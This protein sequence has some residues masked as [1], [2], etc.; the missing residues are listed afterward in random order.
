MATR[1]TRLIASLV[2]RV[3]AP[4][5]AMAGALDIINKAARRND[6]A[7]AAVQ[8]KLVSA[9][10]GAYVF[11]KSFASPI[12]AAMDFED[13]MA[14]VRKVVDF[15]T[16]AE[17]K[18][19][20][21]DV[22]EMSTR[23]P[24]AAKDLSAIVAA[25]GQS[26]FDKSVLLEFTELAA[27]VGVAFDISAGEAGTAL[28]K[29]S[30]GLGLTI[31]QVGALADSMNHLSNNSAASAKDVL[32]VVRRVGAMGKQFGFQA[33]Q[34]AG[35]A[36]AMVAAGAESEVAATSFRNMGLA[37]TKGGGATK[38]QRGAY[39]TLGLD[40]VKVAQ[41]MQKDAVGQTLDVLDR[42]NKLPKWQQAEV[43]NALFGSEARALGPLLTNLDMLRK[44]L[45]MV[46]KETKY[47][48][49]SQKEYEARAATFS[50]DLQLLRNR[51]NRVA[52]I[53]GTALIPAL[54]KGMDILEPVIDAFGRFADK[55][56]G[57]VRA[58]SLTAAALVS[59]R[60]AALAAQFAAL[61][62]KG[63]LLQ[64]AAIAL[65]S[66]L[67]C[68]KLVKAMLIAPVVGAV[69][70]AFRGLRA[71]VVGYAAA[72]AVAGHG[73]ALRMMLLGLLNPAKLA[74]GAIGLVTGALR[75]MKLALISTGIGAILVAI[76][77]AAVFIANNWRGMGQAAEAFGAAFQ[78]AVAPVE[79]LLRPVISAVSTVWGWFSKL[80]G[81][82]DA[83]GKKWEAW[84]TAAGEAV[85]A[86]VLA[87]TQFVQRAATWVSE[88]ASAISSSASQMY[89][90]G[91][92]MVQSLWDG[93]VAKFN[94]FIE[95]V[96][97]IPGRIRAAIG[98]I[99]L[100]N[101][102]K[103]PSFGSTPAA[104]APAGTRANG[105]PVSAG[106]PYLVGERGPELFVP[107][108]SGR[109][110]SSG[111]TR[112]L[113]AATVAGAVAGP[114]AAP[115]MAQ[116]ANVTITNHVTVTATTNTSAREIADQVTRELGNQMRRT[117][118]GTFADVI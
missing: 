94:A 76:G 96:K 34:V 21:A 33:P 73:A 24:M 112:A 102:I 79:P 23:I 87:M 95:W 41:R 11:A 32:D 26:G 66:A 63:A 2:D 29:L 36:A 52:V 114:M 99:D 43:S 30:T 42:I 90:A 37:L 3:T 20:Q 58:L 22:L 5:R 109:V 35:F 82:V 115:A 64:M 46:D 97:G 28:A 113:R 48:G 38:G 85:G 118:D 7:I 88:T 108:Q 51:L 10:A 116:P 45:G 92:A 103:L 68:G 60:V 55:N 27:K 80:T 59:F 12:K 71:A 53:I 104:P 57:L 69:S 6:L 81:E 18:K 75:V 31:P 65:T 4:A 78:K 16:P 25:A 39:A 40:S 83:S 44:V 117:R 101:L 105:G 70:A 67:A 13:S 98:S 100:S 91:Q 74:A 17:F 1:E 77:A 106:S 93:A 111:I 9:A 50:N 72:A 8:Q 15:S 84:G 19:F 54:K 47:L 89:A 62:F 110:E 61:Q 107:R 14:D 49:S 56:P 86:A